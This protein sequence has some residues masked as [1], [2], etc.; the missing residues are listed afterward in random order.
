MKV[1][2]ETDKQLIE[3]LQKNRQYVQSHKLEDWATQARLRGIQE[4]KDELRRRNI[5][6]IDKIL[7][8]GI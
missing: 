7:Q 2:N 5:A 4:I 3:M 8:E 1:Q 6:G